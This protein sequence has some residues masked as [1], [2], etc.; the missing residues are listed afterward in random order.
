[1]ILYNAGMTCLLRVCALAVVLGACGATVEETTTAGPYSCKSLPAKATACAVDADCATVTV[2]CYCG[3][4]PVNG[5]ASGYAKDVQACEDDA[6]SKCALGCLVE[7]QMIAQD[8]KKFDRGGAVGVRCDHTA[9]TGTCKS[10]V[11]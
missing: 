10:Y 8:G 9:A 3:P 4:Q 5:V 2:G 1:V 7:F 6:A 11:P